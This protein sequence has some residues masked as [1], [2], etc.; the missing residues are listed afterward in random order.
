MV[1]GGFDN[2]LW[3]VEIQ[4]V[5]CIIT[6]LEF[7][8]AAVGTQCTELSRGIMCKNVNSAE[9]GFCLV[10]LGQM[11]NGVKIKKVIEWNV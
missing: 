5:G 7:I 9:G 2:G 4:G 3:T 8:L 11:E 10:F 6:S 1:T